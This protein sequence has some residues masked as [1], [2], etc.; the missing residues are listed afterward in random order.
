MTRLTL[1]PTALAVLILLAADGRAVAGDPQSWLKPSP[2]A[3]GLW[4]GGAPYRPRHYEELRRG[5][6][7]GG[8]PAVRAAPLRR[9]AG[10]LPADGDPDRLISGRVE[11]VP[12]AVRDASQKSP[13][14]LRSV[15][16]RGRGSR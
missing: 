1:T 11:L 4:R 15:A 10:S 12:F 13:L 8:S 2:V 9:R 3:P 6:G 5:R 7:G 14:L 16:N